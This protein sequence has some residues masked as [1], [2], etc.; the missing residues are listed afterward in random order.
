MLLSILNY[1]SNYFKL[2]AG[3]NN[4]F[5]PPNIFDCKR[6]EQK[7]KV[8]RGM[9]TLAPT[10]SVLT[11]ICHNIFIVLHSVFNVRSK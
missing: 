11:L 6:T 10:T 7:L 9:I 8:K 2:I 1:L 5:I 4:F 3:S